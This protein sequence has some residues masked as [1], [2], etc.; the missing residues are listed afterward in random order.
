MAKSLSKPKYVN[1]SYQYSFINVITRYLVRLA[2]QQESKSRRSTLNIPL[3]CMVCVHP[4]QDAITSCI[5]MDSVVQVGRSTVPIYLLEY[6]PAYERPAMRCQFHIHVQCTYVSFL[7][8]HFTV[9]LPTMKIR[10]DFMCKISRLLLL[11]HKAL[12]CQGLDMTIN[13]LL[14]KSIQKYISQ[15]FL[16]TDL[17]RIQLKEIRCDSGLEKFHVDQR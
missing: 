4:F 1:K 7:W 6:L 9:I 17:K 16:R 5:Y 11:L 14:M 3:Q 13:V 2:S 15:Y 8:F 12:L 10:T